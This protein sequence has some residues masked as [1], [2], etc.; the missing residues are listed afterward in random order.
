DTT[1]APRVVVVNETLTRQLFGDADPTGEALLVDMGG[2][3]ASTTIVGV[4]ADTR[5]AGLRAPPRPEITFSLRQMSTPSFTLLVSAPR[6]QSNLL[7]ILEEAIRR[8]DPNQA[9]VRSYL[10]ADEL[11][12][13]MHRDRFFA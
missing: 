9:V 13:Q 4:V 10:L 8:I 11:G 12:N 5:N 7:R 6:V 2:G 3:V 1:S